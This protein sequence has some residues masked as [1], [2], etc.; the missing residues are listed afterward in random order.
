[1]KPIDF[2]RSY[3]TFFYPSYPNNARITLDAACT[4][5]D[6]QSGE[7]DIFYLNVPVRHEGNYYERNADLFQLPNFDWCAIWSEKEHLFIRTCTSSDRDQ[8]ERSSSP[9]RFS[10]VHM[11]IRSLDNHRPLADA[12]QIVQSVK[13]SL[14][15]VART[16]LRDEQRHLRVTLEYP[17]KTINF[18]DNPARFQVDTGPVIVPDFAATMVNAIQRFDLAFVNYNTLDRAEFL[19]RRP[20]PVLEGNNLLCSVTDYQVPWSVP[21][22]TEFYADTGLVEQV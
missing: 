2:A 10:E 3:I 11:N 21:A 14:P 8:R 5:T 20:S 4:L 19:L 7:S 22:R 15:L 9:G 18:L 13:D 6:E 1:M 16:E 17:V 12:E